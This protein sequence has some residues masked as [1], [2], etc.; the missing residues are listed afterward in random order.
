[1]FCI[2]SAVM[3]ACYHSSGV[4]CSQKHQLVPGPGFDV[5]RGLLRMEAEFN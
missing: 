5:S 3:I 1:M 4:D 2:I